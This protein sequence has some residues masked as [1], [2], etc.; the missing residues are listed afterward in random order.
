MQDLLQNKAW[1]HIYSTA[2]MLCALIANSRHLLK[3]PR[4]CQPVARMD[5]FFKRLN[6]SEE[7]EG[8]LTNTTLD[9][10]KQ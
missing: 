9:V 6:W 4:M 2:D 5:V 7:L 3:Y 8:R 10:E 1:T